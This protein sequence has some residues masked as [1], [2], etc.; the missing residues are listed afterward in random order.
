M[1]QKIVAMFLS[2]ALAASAQQPKIGETYKDSQ[3][4][5]PPDGS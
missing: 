2:F 3:G 4:Y 5:W 1:T